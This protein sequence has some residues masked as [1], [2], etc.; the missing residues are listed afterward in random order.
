MSILN[1][2][3]LDLAC[4]LSLLTRLPVSWLFPPSDDHHE[5]PLPFARSLWCWPL[6]GLC[7]GG[8][9]GGILWILEM[10]HVPPLVAACCAL[11]AQA[12]LTGALH[13]DGLSDMADGFGG[14]T[15]EQR[16][17]IMRDSHIGS[18]GV[19][20]LCL[21]YGI[22]CGA[23]ASFSMGAMLAPFACGLAGG[24]ARMAIVSLPV[25]LPP[26]RNNGL[27]ATLFP[28]PRRALI[29]AFWLFSFFYV[30]LTLSFCFVIPY[31]LYKIT[32]DLT[33]PIFVT[34]AVVWGIA[35]NA[36]TR[37]GGYTGDVLGCCAV[38]VECFVLTLFSALF[39]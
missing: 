33:T 30:V 39:A 19:I 35:H 38:V 22:R 21:S 1:A 27:A 20:A 16:L 15:P 36:R 11:A 5:A 32:L 12:F 7:I 10:L 34:A 6:L 24:L 31:S 29:G 18:Y 37:L 23:L 9:T 26:A 13:E 4:G 8:F 2:L 17:M 25:F 3:L 14:Q 28:L